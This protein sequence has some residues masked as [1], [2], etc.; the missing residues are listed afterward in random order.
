[1]ALLHTGARCRRMPGADCTAGD[2]KTGVPH[3]RPGEL[4]ATHRPCPGLLP[5]R[6][7][8]ATLGRGTQFC[9]TCSSCQ[10]TRRHSQM[11]F[12][13]FSPRQSSAGWGINQY[14]VRATMAIPRFVTVYAAH[15]SKN[16]L[17]GPRLTKAGTCQSGRV[18]ERFVIPPGYFTSK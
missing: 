10:P 8:C 14:N 2:G 9:F 5:E 17:P 6:Q 1:M 13:A 18:H 11:V 7:H 16:C 12:P 4:A 3:T 15:A